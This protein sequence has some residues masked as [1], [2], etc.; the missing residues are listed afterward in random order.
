M[1]VSLEGAA[2]IAAVHFSIR[3][4]AAVLGRLCLIVPHSSGECTAD[5]APSKV[6]A[7]TSAQPMVKADWG[8]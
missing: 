8:Q 6:G 2:F 5:L 7:A 4:V 1:C 3:F